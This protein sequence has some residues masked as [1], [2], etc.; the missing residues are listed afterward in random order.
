MLT[1]VSSTAFDSWHRA[2]AGVPNS[3]AQAVR[4]RVGARVPLLTAMVAFAQPLPMSCDTVT[5]PLDAE[6]RAATDCWF[7]ARTNS[8]PGYAEGLSYECWTVV[9]TPAYAAREIT[10]TPM[11]TP[12]GTFVPQEKATSAWLLSTWSTASWKPL[13]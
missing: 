7:A 10:S 6:G 12:E 5:F 11:Q 1:D 2:S 4:A 9:G 8:K 3:F 13:G